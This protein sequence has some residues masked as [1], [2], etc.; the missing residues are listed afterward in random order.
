[1][2]DGFDKEFGNLIID[3]KIEF[4]ESLGEIQMDY[5]KKI[6]IHS[7]RKEKKG[8]LVLAYYYKDK[9]EVVKELMNDEEE[10]GSSCIQQ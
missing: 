9:E 8:Q 3:L 5:L 6:L 10:S 7:D 2:S 4:P 1:M